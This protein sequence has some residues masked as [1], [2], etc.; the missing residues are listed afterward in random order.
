MINS[1][2]QCYSISD[3]RLTAKR[4]LPRAVFEYIDG[5]S[6]DEITVKHNRKA[7]DHYQL[8]AKALVDVS[9]ID[10]STTVL[11]EKIDLPFILSPT[12]M[13]KLFHHQGESAVALAAKKANIIYTLSS[14]STTSIE[15]IANLSLT[16]KWFQIYVWR[17]RSLLKDFIQ[18][19]KLSGYKAL[20]LTVDLPTHGNR[21]RDLRNGLR[22][23]PKPSLP[24]MLDILRHPVWLYH[25]LRSD[26]MRLA[27]ISDQISRENANFVLKDYIESQFDPSVT[28]E[29]AKW[30]IEQWNGPF[31]IKGIMNV[32]DAKQAV[33]IGASAIVISNHGGRQLDHA[34]G[35]L[36]LLPEIMDA[37]GDKLEVLIDG[38]FRRG[39]DIIKA[40]ALGAKACMIGRP[41]L[42]G[43]GAGGTQGVSR[44]IEL[45]KEELHR[46]MQLIG[47]RSVDEIDASI[48]RCS[49]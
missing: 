3:L 25:Y 2:N 43:L 27:N 7:F 31:V 49:K 26:P 1:L 17:D 48:I 9:N 32:K 16:P 28:W 45:L 11:G 13:T 10:L 23:P 24:T 14:M 35:T 44:A 29:D 30:M 34:P 41:Y 37:V 46:D 33:N 19:C 4:K 42:Y 39:T 12:A 15:E 21:E 38:G 36:E 22:I 47:C 18:R 5:G 20:C 40:L 8:N 6:E